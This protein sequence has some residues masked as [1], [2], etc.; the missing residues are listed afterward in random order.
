MPRHPLKHVGVNKQVR[1]AASADPAPN[2]QVFSLAAARLRRLRERHATEKPFPLELTALDMRPLELDRM[3]RGAR[4][5]FWFNLNRYARQLFAAASELSLA[6]PGQAHATVTA[7][8]VRRAETERMRRILHREHTELGLVFLLDAL[9]IV[10]A[11]VCGALATKPDLLG[12]GGAWP[13]A[14]A[15]AAT[16]AVFLARETFAARAS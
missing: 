6:E 14:G 15:L 1:T 13:L 11:A 5:H 16:V 10:G 9:Q 2:G 7:E 8:H 4:E 12:G 3:T